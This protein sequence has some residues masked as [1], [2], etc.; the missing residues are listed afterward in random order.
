MFGMFKGVS[1]FFANIFTFGGS[2]FAYFALGTWGAARKENPEAGFLDF[3]KKWFL[4]P[5]PNVLEGAKGLFSSLT[6]GVSSLFGAGKS[7]F[8]GIS[9]SSTSTITNPQVK[10]AIEAKPE[11]GFTGFKPIKPEDGKLVVGDLKK[12]F[13]GANLVEGRVESA[14]K[15]E[16]QAPP[17]PETPKK[18]ASLE[19]PYN[20]DK[21]IVA[22]ISSSPDFGKVAPGSYSKKLESITDVVARAAAPGAPKDPAEGPAAPE[23]SEYHVA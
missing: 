13:G 9:S 21:Q 2:L 6:N 4:D 20:E 12:G 19:N 10:A 23:Y 8:E 14:P 7:V 1:D 11:E 22:S 15:K 3:A 17:A 5:L 18:K 16:E